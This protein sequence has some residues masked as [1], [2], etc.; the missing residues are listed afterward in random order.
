MEPIVSIITGTYNRIKYLKQMIRSARSSIPTGIT[1]EFVVTDGG[2]TDG[3]IEWLKEQNDVVLIEH[4]ELKGAIKAFNDAAAKAI[5]MY[6][7]PANDDI[8]FIDD[9]IELLL[10]HIIEH[11]DVGAGC[12]YQDREGKHWHVEHMQVIHDNGT[13]MLTPYVQVGI[14]PRWLWN[15]CGG[16]GDFGSNTYG[17]DN[18]VSAKIMEAGYKI[19]AVDGARIHDLTP[20]DELRKHNNEINIGGRDGKKF[21][22]AF[23]DGVK[24]NSEPQIVNPLASLKKIL[25][26]PIFEAG[27]DVQ[28]QQKTGLRTALQKLGAVW[29]VNHHGGNESIAAAA[30]KWKPNFVLTQIHDANKDR[31]A[32]MSSVRSCTKDW[33]V[34]WVGDVW[35]EQQKTPEYL[36]MLRNFDLHTGVN[37]SLKELYD[38]MSIPY[39]YWQ[40]GFEPFIEDIGSEGDV[41]IDVVFIAN[42]YSE[43][44]RELASKLKSLPCN[45]KIYGSGYEQGI[46]EGSTLY[47][48][49]ATG[50]IIRRA[51]IVISDN[52]FPNDDGFR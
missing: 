43:Q 41:D 30:K 27:H 48:F 22:E 17:G 38:K 1:Y 25:Y 13:S 12:C 14:I 33:M 49:R 37:Y 20:Y 32:E 18:Y 28:I 24:Y 7:I 45:V 8:I 26:A 46:S 23:P 40:I 39:H 50:N 10:S 47:D 35:P 3:T 42:G 5:G 51:K 15:Y 19:E 36:A 6:V 2:S 29:E 11:P 9:T 16:W 4:G 52:Q 44:R 31:V 21:Y 34:N